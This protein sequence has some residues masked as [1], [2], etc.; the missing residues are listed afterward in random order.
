MRKCGDNELSE[1]RKACD[2]YV[3]VATPPADGT[4]EMALDLRR[5]RR[6]I[7]L[8]LK[9][10]KSLFKYHETPARVEASAR[11]WLHGKLLLAAICEAWVDG[12][13]FSPS[14]GRDAR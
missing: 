1:A 8:A 12:G 5:Q 6:R 11:A 4:P 2:R 9:R 13:R 3:I 10:L 14:E 7:E